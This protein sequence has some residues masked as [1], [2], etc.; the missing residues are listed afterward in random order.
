MPKP[1]TSKWPRVQ[2]LIECHTCKTK[3]RFSIHYGEST[4]WSNSSAGK[5]AEWAQHEGHDVELH[6]EFYDGYDRSATQIG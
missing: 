6:Y 3:F 1:A 5:L 2:F 4:I